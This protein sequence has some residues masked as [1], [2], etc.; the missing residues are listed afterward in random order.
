MVIKQ[1]TDFKTTLITWQNVTNS[2]VDKPQQ[3]GL[4]TQI[5]GNVPLVNINSLIIILRVWLYN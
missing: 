2:R 1:P 5:I 4:M 3:D